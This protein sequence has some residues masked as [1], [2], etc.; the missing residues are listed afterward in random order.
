MLKVKE[1]Y[2]FFILYFII[3]VLYIVFSDYLILLF[4]SNSS[5]I[6]HIQSFKGVIFVASTTIAFLFY[7][8]K[9]QK[10]QDD[11]I[12]K[13]KNIWEALI[14]ILN[15]IEYKSFII[16]GK[17]KVYWANF[18]FK[19]K[20]ITINDIVS[21]NDLLDDVSKIKLD[22]VISRLNSIDNPNEAFAN[23]EITLKKEN[24]IIELICFALLIPSL[25]K[26]IILAQ[27]KT[28]KNVD[29]NKDSILKFIVKSLALFQK[30][31]LKDITLIELT[32]FSVYEGPFCRAFVLK[33]N[34]ENW[35]LLSVNDKEKLS[36]LES[37]QNNRIIDNYSLLEEKELF[38]KK[39]I[40]NKEKGKELEEFLELTAE[41]DFIG[42]NLCIYGKECYFIFFVYKLEDELK[43]SFIDIIKLF[44]SFA[45]NEIDEKN[46]HLDILNL[47]EQLKED[48]YRLE[49][50]ANLFDFPVFICTMKGAIIYAN[51]FACNLINKNKDEISG[52]FF[53]DFIEQ[54]DYEIANESIKKI[55]VEEK[56]EVEF[57]AAI[58]SVNQISKKILWKVARKEKYLF[59]WGS[60]D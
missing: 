2:N 15:A 59:C 36:I 25:E 10:K 46:K 13:E 8:S 20:D 29:G 53:L 33:R 22:S 31:N 49:S 32:R 34:D 43:Q 51:N 3:S 39:D 17:G 12:A 37:K 41:E 35:H 42:V 44:L 56:N 21:I 24:N 50:L 18:S 45:K 5:S 47:K 6:T 54:K 26:I 30:S 57:K 11:L 40:Q 1:Q 55:T 58:Y 28:K 9:I 4:Y 19:G 52:T 7:F 23:F 38:S 60:K 48:N 27:E 16:D 14:R